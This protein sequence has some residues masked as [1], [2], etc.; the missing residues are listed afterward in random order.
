MEHALRG[1]FSRP[2]ALGIRPIGSE[3]FI[4]PQHDPGCARRGVSFLSN[5]SEQYDY[6]LLLFDHEGSGKE[7]NAPEELERTLGEEFTRSAWGERARAIV[8]SPELEAW[9]WSNSPHVDE[10]AGW[11]QRRPSLHDWLVE[12]GFLQE[13]QVKPP[14][15]KEAFRAALRAS[16]IARSASLYQQ[17]AEKVSLHGCADRS[18]RELRR[19]LRT[20]FP[21]DPLA[22]VRR[23]S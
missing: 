4:H 7:Q 16:R 11:A 23:H 5:F 22:S 8:V 6:G 17:I 9:V 2:E 14:R 19:T 20:W 18:F 13:G 3:T 12:S 1:L 10:V 15:P 21:Q